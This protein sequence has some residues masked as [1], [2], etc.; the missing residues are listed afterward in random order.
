L[1]YTGVNNLVSRISRT[2]DDE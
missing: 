1:D 2:G